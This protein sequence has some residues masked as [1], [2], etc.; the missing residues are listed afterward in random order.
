M[1]TKTTYAS[2]LALAAAAVLVFSACGGG[3][4]SGA[5]APAPSGM[6]AAQTISVSNVDGVGEVLVDQ[7]GAALYAADEEA[8]GMV[9][10]TESCLEIWDPLTVDEGVKPTA[11]DGLAGKL[12]VK[13]RPEGRQVTLNGR[14]LYSFQLDPD[15]GT[16]T[17]NGLVDVFDGKSFTWHVATP[18]GISS[19]SQNTSQLDGFDY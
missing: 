1:K 5:E 18:T 19:S 2:V 6:N 7:E 10:C 9:V 16:V 15:P 13:N 17:G 3:S 14:L 4:E 11:A 8:N 12:A